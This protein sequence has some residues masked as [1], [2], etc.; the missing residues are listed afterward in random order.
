MRRA[1]HLFAALAGGV[2]LAA[3]VLDVWLG[4]EVTILHRT[5]T[6][7]EREA[8]RREVLAPG[9][10]PAEAYGHPEPGRIR[11]LVLDA[12]RL[13]VPPEAPGRRFLSVDRAGGERVWTATLLWSLAALAASVL[14]SAAAFC[15][16]A[17]RRSRPALPS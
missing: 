17:S 10:D 7:E 12:G 13:V 2:L 11:V 5:K 14:A 1:G 9:D 16:L 15:L 3:L 8:F 4:V 6:A